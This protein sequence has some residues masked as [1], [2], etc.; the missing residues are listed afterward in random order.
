MGW[1]SILIGQANVQMTRTNY[2]L[3]IQTTVIISFVIEL[4]YC[5]PVV[6]HCTG[7]GSVRIADQVESGGGQ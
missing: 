1:L 5:S 4:H 6:V 3:S 7:T 2:Y